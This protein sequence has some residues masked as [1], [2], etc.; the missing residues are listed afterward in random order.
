MTHSRQF[1]I[2]ALFM[3]TLFFCYDVTQHLGHQGMLQ[4]QKFCFLNLSRYW[5]LNTIRNQNT[6][7]DIIYVNSRSTACLASS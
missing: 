3:L 5:R 7:D 4:E 2:L 1:Y 6:V